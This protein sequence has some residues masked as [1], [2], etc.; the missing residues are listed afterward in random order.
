MNDIVNVEVINSKTMDLT[1][2]KDL[3]VSDDDMPNIQK[4]ADSIIIGDSK[5]VSD[6]GITIAENASQYATALLEK[7]RSSDLDKTGKTIT[8]VLKESRRITATGVKNKSSIPIIGVIFDK[9][10]LFRANVQDEY[11]SINEQLNTLEVEINST[12]NGLSEINVGLETDFKSVMNEIKMLALHS[13]ALDLKKCEL[14]LMISE[15]EKVV[16][17]GVNMQQLSDLKDSYE[18]ISMKSANIK[19]VA[20]DAL[21]TLPMIRTIQKSNQLSISKLDTVKTL[22]ISVMR[23]RASLQIAMNEGKRALD[24]EKVITDANNEMIKE[25]SRLLNKNAVDAATAN[26]RLAIDVDTLTGAQQSLVETLKEVDAINQKGQTERLALDSKLESLRNN[27]LTT[28]SKQKI[29]SH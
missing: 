21:L 16:T 1:Q 2:Y 26:Q 19:I 25:Q 8:N 11:K 20:H 4:L 5:M 10:N 3:G 27:L 14:E 9:I 28:C 18:L 12:R 13:A 6:F 17:G 7:V 22:T 29:I 24:L 23:R 15:Q